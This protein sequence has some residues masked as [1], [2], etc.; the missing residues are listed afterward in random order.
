MEV[1]AQSHAP[2]A[3][4][5][6]KESPVPIAEEAGWAPEPAWALWRRGN[7]FNL[8]VNR[9]TIP[10]SPVPNLVTVP[11]TLFRHIPVL[12]KLNKVQ[13]MPLV[14]MNYTLFS[15]V[16]GTVKFT[17]AFIRACNWSPSRANGIPFPFPHTVSP[18]SALVIFSY[19]LLCL[20]SVVSL[21]LI[22]FKQPHYRP[23]QALRGPG[24]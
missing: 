20:I 14:I 16:Y 4:L 19:V 17:T 21:S 11:T 6:G 22:F 2:A 7:C 18:L 23:R 10:R 9:T 15:L 13:R 12:N 5:P 3:F 24:G 1:M 8:A